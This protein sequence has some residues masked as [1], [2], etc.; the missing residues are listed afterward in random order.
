MTIQWHYRRSELIDEFLGTFITASTNTLTL[1]APRRMG[2][3]EFILYD[4]IPVASDRGFVPVYV[5]F[6]EH[7]NDPVR[8]LQAG[9]AQA[10]KDLKW[11]QKLRAFE[12]S[13]KSFQLAGEGV[14][15]SV[16]LPGASALQRPDDNQLV[17]LR[18]LFNQLLATRKPILLCLDEIQHLA[19]DTAFEP[20]VYFLRTI[21]DRHR[22]QLKVVYTGS[23]RDGLQRLFRRRKAPL[24]QSSSQVDLPELGASFVQHI[25]AAFAEASGRQVPLS[26][27]LG[28]FRLVKKVP[29]EFRQ[30]VD[31]MLRAGVTDIRQVTESYLVES[32]D[33]AG[34]QDAWAAMKPIDQAI[35]MRLLM[36]GHGLYSDEARAAIADYLGLPLHQVTK[37]AVQN[38]VNRMRGV[39]ITRVEHGVWDFE[40]QQFRDWIADQM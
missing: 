25:L 3:T 36:S 17:A 20:L 30:I 4:L 22:E 33:T 5:S 28:A 31:I 9:L 32:I 16:E 37:H 6:W 15:A 29:F 35:L 2:K 40:D 27:A 19:T 23:S 21:I 7:R 39:Y 26:E 12:F 34:Y 10:Q 24:F 38:A 13:P 1:F 11:A 14:S 18:S 8:C